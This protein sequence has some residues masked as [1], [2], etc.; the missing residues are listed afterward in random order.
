MLCMVEANGKRNENGGVFMEWLRVWG[1][2]GARRIYILF[3]NYGSNYY[4]I[5]NAFACLSLSFISIFCVIKVFVFFFKQNCPL[6][7][8]SG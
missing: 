2:D 7:K 1:I 4:C 5:F 3:F 8:L 6:D